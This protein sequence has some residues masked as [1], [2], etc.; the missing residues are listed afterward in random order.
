[1]SALEDLRSPSAA[2]AV[3]GEPA[4]WSLLLGRSWADGGAALAE[5]AALAGADDGPDGERATR[6]ALEA[7]GHGLADGDPDGWTVD[8]AVAAVVSPALASAAAQHVTVLTGALGLGLDEELGRRAGDL[9]RGLGYLTLDEGASR[10]VR[11]AL[12]EWARAQPVPTALDH[13]PLPPPVVVVPSAFLAVREYG[14]RLAYALH[15]FEAQAEAEHDELVWN[16]T[17]GTLVE[18]FGRRA[19]P[20]LPIIEGYA[21]MATGN[22]GW[23]DNGPDQGLRFDRDDAAAAVL[24]LTPA[25]GD[26]REVHAGSARAV[27]DRTSEALGHPRP[28]VPEERDRFGPVKDA[29]LDAPGD[30]FLDDAGPRGRAPVR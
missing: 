7:L 5:V 12:A 20:V 22:D 21:A 17:A 1:V 9:L 6:L 30:R 10:T 13:G 23:W 4:A 25:V 27:F 26:G 11:T 2:A 14:Q 18:T 19:G 8:R 16:L 24:R 3:L 28:P 15:G 29:F